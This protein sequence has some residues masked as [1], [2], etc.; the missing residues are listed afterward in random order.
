M[1]NFRLAVEASRNAKSVVLP[2][3]PKWR[4][5]VLAVLAVALDVW[6]SWELS[7]LLH[8]LIPS[9]TLP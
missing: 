2:E 9:E 4:L 8:R 6:R 3:A 1:A 7:E 5:K